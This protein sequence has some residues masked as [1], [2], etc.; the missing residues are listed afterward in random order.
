MDEDVRY[1]LSWMCVLPSQYVDNPIDLL[2][3][4]TVY[5]LIS[6][7][8]PFYGHMDDDDSIDPLPE[9][10]SS[11][12]TGR[13]M[14]CMRYHPERRPD[15]L[16]LMRT[17]KW[18]KLEVEPESSH[19]PNP[20]AASTSQ[21]LP[22]SRPV[23]SAQTQ[24]KQSSSLPAFL[25]PLEGTKESQ[26]SP[27]VSITSTYPTINTNLGPMT[28]AEI[29][30]MPEYSLRT[31]TPD[32]LKRSELSDN[33]GPPQ[34]EPKKKSSWFD[35]I[36]A[37]MG[38]GS[39]SE[40]TVMGSITYPP[41]GT[42][43]Y[44]KPQVPPIQPMGSAAHPPTGPYIY[45]NPQ[46]PPTVEATNARRFQSST[47]RLLV[48]TL[49]GKTFTVEVDPSATIAQLKSICERQEGTPR[50]QMRLIFVGKQL[51]DSKSLSNY[52]ITNEATINLVRI[53]ISNPELIIKTLTGRTIVVEHAPQDTVLD[54]KGKI[55]HS[56]RMDP[57]QQRL[58]FEG[59]QLEDMYTL[60][61][62]NIG[63]GT[64]VHLVQ[65]LRV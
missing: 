26:S 24:P 10:C 61:Q 49:T 55:Y 28:A 9:T 21:R 7:K 12:L 5:E 17:I 39:R 35:K 23:Q 58:I 11:K 20:H 46:V 44:S 45:P 64:T 4:G 19:T 36:G 65:R 48:K 1:I 15:V 14:A 43:T 33:R 2:F 34:V 29:D 54:L 38:L 30:P 53:P 56:I 62:Y 13:V 22:S 8:P 32:R 31:K 57:S 60:Q 6:L 63:P 51:E 52:N 42:P 3:A 16:D 59:K 41:A 18:P 50:D 47:L 37:R 40:K 27:A 25:S